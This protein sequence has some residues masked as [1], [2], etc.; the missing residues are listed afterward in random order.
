MTYQDP[1]IEPCSCGRRV[2][3]KA[4]IAAVKA[5]LLRNVGGG[6]RIQVKR[7]GHWVRGN[8]VDYANLDALERAAGIASKCA[9]MTSTLLGQGVPIHEAVRAAK[10]EYHR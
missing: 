10:A 6:F 2:S 3:R 7:A 1:V 5:V 4:R 9:E 8:H